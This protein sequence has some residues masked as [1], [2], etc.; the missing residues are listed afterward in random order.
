MLLVV[1]P[2]KTLDFETPAP[3]LPV[4]RPV[5]RTD[6]VQLAARMREYD[7]A[8]LARLMGISADLASLNVDRFRAFSAR[9]A[10]ARQRPAV[11][12][13]RGDTY[14]GMRAD[15]FDAADM[16]FAQAHLR[17]LS[18]LYGL[19]RPLDLI[20]PYRLEMGSAV[21]TARGPN[22]YAWWGSRIARELRKQAAATGSGVLVNLASQEYFAAVDTDAL[23]LRVVTP[24][25]KERRG[26][27]LKI[28]S[29]SAKRA[30]GAMAAFAIRNRLLDPEGLKAFAEDD[31]R[32]RPE[33]SSDDAWVFAR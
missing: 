10:A 7:A 6:A 28:V 17:I 9:P 14:I 11:L 30:R 22:L 20:Q 31:Y 15:D 26:G 24:Q 27:V 4:T 16:D 29:F 1:S 13:F 23:G 21:A 18:G 8:G 33:L 3:A 12:A 2:A 19:L 5:F 25:F 32:F